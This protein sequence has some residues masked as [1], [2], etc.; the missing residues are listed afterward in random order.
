MGTYFMV[1][2]K[3][4]ARAVD[5]VQQGL[6][7]APND[8]DLLL[9]AA[10]IERVNGNW[11]DALAHLRMARRL[12]PRSVRAVNALQNAFLWL[13]RYPE[14]LEASEA[15]L[16]LAPGDLSISQDKSMVYLAQGDLAGARSVIRQV[17][18]AVTPEGLA[19]FFG[20]YWDMYWA[21][22]EPLQQVLLRIRPE[23][24]DNDRSTWANVLMQTL[25]LR[26]D[27]ARARIM[28]DSAVIA[29]E[30]VLAQSP[31]DPQRTLF[32]GLALAYQGRKADAIAKGDRALTLVPPDRE[33]VN[34]PYFQHVMARIYLLAGEQEKALD[35]L[36][37][38]LQRPYFVSPGWLRIDPT[39]AELKGHPRFERLLQGP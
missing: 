8:P 27:T 38:I 11:D 23:D 37:A 33:H 35:L 7:I 26:G 14:A 18:P 31:D 15:A 9:R 21:L 32:L 39:F 12:D 29:N 3:D 28:A 10:A 1:V 24:Y 22:D 34:G 6:R 19:A 20:T 5:H 30:Q 36:E 2:R 25:W 17:S 4:V 16:A 13:R